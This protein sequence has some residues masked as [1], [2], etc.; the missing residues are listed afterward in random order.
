MGDIRLMPGLPEEP[1][2][3]GMDV[4]EEGNISGVF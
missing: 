2:A 1:A 3:L 4:D